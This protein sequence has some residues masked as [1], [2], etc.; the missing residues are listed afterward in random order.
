M[1]ILVLNPNSSDV[2][3]EVIMKSARKKAKATTELICLTNPEGTKNIDV[4]TRLPVVAFPHRGLPKSKQSMDAA[5]LRFGN[6]GICAHGA[7]I[8]VA[9]ISEKMPSPAFWGTNS[10]R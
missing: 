8:F 4:P 7:L 3:S 6:V 2:V 5:V 1:K 9:S 10:R